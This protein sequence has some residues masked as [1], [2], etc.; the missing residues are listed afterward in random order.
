MM[1]LLRKFRHLDRD[2]DQ[3]R[4]AA[5]ESRERRHHAQETVIKT[6]RKIAEENNF[7]AIIRESLQIGYGKKNDSPAL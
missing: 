2:L 6:A 5:Q 3:A 4:K 7:A 1:K